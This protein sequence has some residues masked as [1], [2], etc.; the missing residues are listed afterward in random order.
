MAGM[1]VSDPSVS[2][3]EESALT[4]WFREA[5][6]TAAFARWAVTTSSEVA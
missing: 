4:Y 5:I 6:S 3:V 1:L 2:D